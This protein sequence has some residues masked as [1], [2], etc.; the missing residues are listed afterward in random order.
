[1]PPLVE[2]Q[3]RLRQAVVAG[4]LMEVAPLLIGG[5]DPS[6]RLAIHHRHY[7]TSLV[8]AL[9]GKFPATGWLV[10]TTFMTQAARQFV[11]ER[12]PHAL[13]IAEY[14]A[15]FPQFLSARP[16]ADRVPYLRPFAELEW[17]LGQVSVETDQPTLGPGAL[18]AF[19]P[20]ALV[21]AA[22]VLQPGVRYLHAPWPVDGLMRLYLTDTAPDRLSLQPE[23]VWIEVRGAR[24]DFRMTRL[25]AGEFVFRR[26]IQHASTLGEAAERALETRSAFE[27]GRVLAAL[28]AEGLLTAITARN[29]RDEQ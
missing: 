18:S 7:E 12:P 27:L 29:H 9:L 1:M 22:L 14:G 8:T 11:R 26:A 17:H 10:G 25:D 21:D 6:R 3:R 19:R 28:V 5:R 2:T 24:G 23:E 16:A 13:C 4:N 15:E 20:E